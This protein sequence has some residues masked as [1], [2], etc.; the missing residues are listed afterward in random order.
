ME[1][2]GM[3]SLDTAWRNE[4][5]WFKRT[6]ISCILVFLTLSGYIGAQYWIFSIISSSIRT[7]GMVERALGELQGFLVRAQMMVIAVGILLIL[8]CLV[9]LTSMIRWLLA[10]RARRRCL[11]EGGDLISK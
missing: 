7:S 8:S 11:V 3:T 5:K 2:N 6:I 10:I 1:Q 4:R 9:F